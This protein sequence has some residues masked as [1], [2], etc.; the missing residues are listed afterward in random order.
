MIYKNIF[1][2]TLITVLVIIGSTNHLSADI[3][4]VIKNAINNPA[5]LEADIQRDSNRK[6]A[7]VL[8]F[9]TIK[10]GDTVLDLFAGAG[11]YSDLI[12]RMVGDKGKVISHNNTAYISYLGKNA[13]THFADN[14]LPNVQRIVNEA[15]DLKLDENSINVAM[16]ILTFHDFYY[17]S[18]NWK[19]INVDSL[20]SRIKKALKDDGTVVIVDHIAVAGSGEK[21]GGTLHR[22]DPA[23]VKEKMREAGV[24]L[25]DEDDFLT[26]AKD[27]LT[28]SM[29]DPKVRGKTSR[30]VLRYKKG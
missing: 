18:E 27:P 25:V 4:P 14:R 7:K 9:S 3:S 22:I 16:L 11:Y 20:L 21:V 8:K 19:K 6:P 23:I 10:P 26:K 12:S 30:F 13:N 2:T 24:K 28:I 29:G 15:N 1:T 17:S 5:R